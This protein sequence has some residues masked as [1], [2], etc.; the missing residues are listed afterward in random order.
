MRATAALKAKRLLA[1][2][3]VVIVRAGPTG[4]LALV[5]GDSGALREVSWKPQPGFRCSCPSVG[6]CSH[7]IAVASVVLV[8]QNPGAWIDVAS[9]VG[10]A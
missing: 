10:A 1:E 8:P 9:L 4:V 3:R 6:P 2:A 7:G 5:R